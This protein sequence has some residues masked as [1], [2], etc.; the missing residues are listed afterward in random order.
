MWYARGKP[1]RRVEML[2]NAFDHEIVPNVIVAPWVQLRFPHLQ[3][4]HLNLLVCEVASQGMLPSL[5]YQMI[6]VDSHIEACLVVL[7]LWR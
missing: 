6:D 5:F 1:D 4:P 3:N 7:L 2:S